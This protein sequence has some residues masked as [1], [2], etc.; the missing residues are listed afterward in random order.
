V[1]RQKED[2]H[3]AGPP[4][5]LDQVRQLDP[6]H[7]RH[8]DVEDDRGEVVLQHGDERL[9]TRLRAHER[10]AARLEHDLQR[11]QVARVIVDD[12]DPGVFRFRGHGAHR[13]SH[14]R[15]SDSNSSVFTGLAM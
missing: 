12:E 4:A 10:A 2:R 9:I 1:C 6:V 5:L 3:V 7:P 15:S 14:T 11:I 8:P 13:Y